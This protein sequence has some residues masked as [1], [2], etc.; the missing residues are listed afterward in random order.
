MLVSLHKEKLSKSVM[1]ITIFYLDLVFNM[2]Y[3]QA[4]TCFV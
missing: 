1:Q 4:K 2:P 3:T